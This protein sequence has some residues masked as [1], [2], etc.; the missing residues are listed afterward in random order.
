MPCLSLRHREPLTFP[1]DIVEGQGRHLATAK[2]VGHQQQQDRVIPFATRR[3]PVDASQDPPDLG[4]RDRPRNAREP[5][6]LRPLHGPAEIAADQPFAVCVAEKYPQHPAPIAHA[7]LG[8]AGCRALGHERAQQGW[9]QLL[10][11]SDA[12]P[13]EVGLETLEVVPIVA[14]RVWPQPTLRDEVLE[15]P[16]HDLTKRRV[17]MPTAGALETGNDESQQLLDRAAHLFGHLLRR[18]AVLAFAPMVA[19]ALG[20]VRI[21]ISWQV[22]D[23]LRSP[24]ACVLSEREGKRDPP[25]HSTSAVTL[26]G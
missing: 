18:A 13:A 10:H 14:N 8:Q 12:D 16:W 4:P 9:R 21:Y 5:V 15:E 22:G 7:R 26:V 11:V 20:H 6:H 23:P 25:Q 3:S 17:A 2:A 19:D 1:I 24:L